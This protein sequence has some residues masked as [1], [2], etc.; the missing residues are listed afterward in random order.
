M[1]SVMPYNAP[2]R[3]LIELEGGIEKGVSTMRVNDLAG[4]SFHDALPRRGFRF[5]PELVTCWPAAGGF[6]NC[7]LRKCDVAT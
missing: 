1:L 5:A 7:H 3:I 2:R 4:V 6:D